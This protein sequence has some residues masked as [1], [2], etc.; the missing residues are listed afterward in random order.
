MESRMTKFNGLHY[1]YRALDELK[2]GEIAYVSFDGKKSDSVVVL[3][4]INERYCVKV[5]IKT[6]KYKGQY[7]EFLLDEVRL[8]P[9]EAKTNCVTN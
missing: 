9:E 6:G 7:K 4:V 2:E 1:K 3:T 5:Q 8:T